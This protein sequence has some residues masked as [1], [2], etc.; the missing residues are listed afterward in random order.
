MHTPPVLV[1]DYQN[2]SLGST[3]FLLQ[4]AGFSVTQVIDLAQALNLAICRHHSNAP[5]GFLAASN[6]PDAEIV[7][8]VRLLRQAGTTLP[9]LLTCRNIPLAGEL[10][11][12]AAELDRNVYLCRPD[13]IGPAAKTLVEF[14]PT[15]VRKK[16]CDTQT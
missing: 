12:Q 9:L 14:E 4:L 16:P 7:R 13:Q 3:G 6:L 10:L 1:L 15:T 8:I 2:Q 5:F 11:Y